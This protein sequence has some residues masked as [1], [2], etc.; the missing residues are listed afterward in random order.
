MTSPNLRM[1][2][3]IFISLIRK[4]FEEP[5]K[6]PRPQGWARSTILGAVVSTR[7]FAR[8]AGVHVDFHADRHFDD[9]WSFPGHRGLL[10]FVA[11]AL[12]RQQPRTMP[13]AAQA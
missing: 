10:I 1:A 8:G 12:R 9:F 11:R 13:A 5:S 4:R 6:R 3:P 7:L 2:V